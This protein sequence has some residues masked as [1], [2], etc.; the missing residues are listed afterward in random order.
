MKIRFL[1]AH[2]TE[3]RDTRLSGL[4]VDGVIALDAGGLTSSLTLSEQ[5][6][7]KTVLVTHQHYDH[8][9]D[10]PLLAMNH[11]LN[12]SSFDVYCLPE[13]GEIISKYLMDGKLYSEFLKKKKDGKA[14]IYLH[15]AEPYH[16]MQIEKYYVTAVPVPHGVPSVGYL[17]SSTDDK[18]VFY[19]GDTG[20][21]ISDCF[22]NI[23]VKLLI[24]EV[25]A[26]NDYVEFCREKGHLC[27]CLLKEELL[28]HLNIKGYIPEII[29]VHMNK[30]LEEDIKAGLAKIADELGISIEMAVEG[31]QLEI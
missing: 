2:N 25:T 11:F 9:K 22:K 15:N 29:T 4:L 7:I 18:E 28:K 1:G 30:S 8:I 24:I 21:G 31:K 3:T 27:P 17:F 13:T 20:P 19:S 6:A 16:K 14:V 5:L 23:S 26:S 10:L 12:N